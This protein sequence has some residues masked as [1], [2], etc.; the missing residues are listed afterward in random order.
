MESM[1]GLGEGHTAHTTLV[2]AGSGCVETELKFIVV[3]LNR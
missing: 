3:I 1:R 2:I